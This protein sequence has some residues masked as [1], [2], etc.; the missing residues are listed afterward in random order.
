[1]KMSIVELN[2]VKSYGDAAAGG[3]APKQFFKI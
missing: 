3:G 1:M 2:I